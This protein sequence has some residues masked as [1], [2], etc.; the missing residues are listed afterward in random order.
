MNDSNRKNPP[1]A[2]GAAPEL[3]VLTDRLGFP[4]LEFDTTV[5]LIE[6]TI[7]KAEEQAAAGPP[8]QSPARAAPAAP[9][10]Q[11]APL[12]AASSPRMY[13]G[14][15]QATPP[16]AAARPAPAPA[17]AA[18]ASGAGTAPAPLD[19]RIRAQWENEVRNAVLRG[20]SERLPAEIE[21]MV[22]EQLA[23]A[24]DRFV[25]DL[26]AQAR[27]AIVANLRQV[28]DQAVRAE[29]ARLRPPPRGTN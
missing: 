12:P 27:G 3:P 16:P 24:V 20:L 29:L 17:A 13:G 19:P 1:P 10:P 26:A 7:L 21:A 22:R 8:T 5:P 9:A 18:P 14:A 23:P 28:I 4:P 25:E 6:T 2:A 11:G 15:G